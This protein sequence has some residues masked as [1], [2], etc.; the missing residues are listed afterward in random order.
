MNISVII[1]SR[2]DLPGQMAIADAL[3]GKAD[4]F[5]RPVG[6]ALQDKII[7]PSAFNPDGKV[8][9]VVLL[10]DRY[11]I[12]KEA[13]HQREIGNPIAH[14]HAGE[15]TGQEPD[16]T[17]R[18]VISRMSRWCFVP[19]TN[20]YTALAGIGLFGNKHDVFQYR[21]KCFRCGSPFITSA[22]NAQLVNTA[23][24]WPL[25]DGPK[26]FACFNPLPENHAETIGIA[27]ALRLLQKENP[28]YRFVVI[29]PNTDRHRDVIRE[30]WNYAKRANCID[31]VSH[32]E[33]LSL[34]R[35]C[36]IMIG[37]SSAGLI[38]GSYFG[39]PYVC[40]GSRQQFREKGSHVLHCQSRAMARYISKALRM[41]R[42]PN[43]SY[44]GTD[45]AERIA[46]TLIRE[47]ECFKTR[48]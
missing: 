11:E 10:G 6:P 28:E 20:G 13:L 42:K 15:M 8:D 38:E 46:S 32:E 36:D 27:T 24:L 7:P 22:A 29:S 48:I 33:Y 12:A 2:A 14:I 21:I 39:V 4:V 9:C 19:Q 18:D 17:Y 35:D 45:S 31:S 41:G 1:G 47:I 3:K 30:S 5:V 44:G 26:I 34:M 23:S 37:N 40:V 43:E 16:D 25:G